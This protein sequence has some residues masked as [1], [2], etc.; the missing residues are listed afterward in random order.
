M[1]LPAWCIA[2]SGMGTKYKRVEMPRRTCTFAIAKAPVASLFVSGGKTALR[3]G[4]K[5][6]AYIAAV[7]M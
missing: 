4:L 2:A 7:A 1:T 6:D 3:A 5:V